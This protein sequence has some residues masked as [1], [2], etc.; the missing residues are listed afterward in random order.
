MKI[1]ILFFG[2]LTDIT[3]TDS[4]EVK[5]LKDTNELMLFLNNSYPALEHSKYVLAVNTDVVSENTL[6]T[7]DCTVALLPPFSGG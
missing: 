3:G 6:L 2:Q 4:I 7:S 1:N 5:D